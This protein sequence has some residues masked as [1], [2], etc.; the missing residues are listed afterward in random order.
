MA[1]D[2]TVER[3]V[4]GIDFGE[5]PRWRD[6]RL[7]WS[8]F[9]QHTISSVAPTGER[10]VELEYGGQ[11]SGLGWLPD[12]RLL[13][14]SMLDRRLLR[15]EHDGSVVEH[16]DLSS[17]AT[18]NCN[19]MVVDTTGRAY[20]GNF[21]F[22][23]PG[24]ADF[25]PAALALVHPDGTVEQAADDLRFPNGSVI[26]P[27]T[28][29]GATLIVGETFGGRYTAFDVDEATGRLSNR[30]IWAEIP[31]TAPDGCAVDAEGAIWFSDALGAQVVRVREGGEVAATI[32]TSAPTY[33]C[34]LGGD[35]GRTLFILTAVDSHPDQVAGTATG[36]IYTTRVD[37]P[38]HP[39]AHP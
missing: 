21:G 12:G 3:L 4:D 37:V 34:M 26:V 32:A 2:G 33:A 23:L 28:D 6:G 27:S 30:R 16:A 8:D 24:R 17:I 11:P 5:G 22:D 18:D 13:F 25:A 7:W 9:Y 19:D 10:R 38:R 15:R 20:V 29:G 1:N 31:G 35:D 36:A 14:V 39:T